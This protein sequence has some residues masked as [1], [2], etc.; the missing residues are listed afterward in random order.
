MTAKV[1]I[2]VRKTLN[3]RYFLVVAWFL[4]DLA[5]ILK[6]HFQLAFVKEPMA[7]VS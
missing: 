7:E 1:A 2:T 3:K 6:Y 5:R 4:R